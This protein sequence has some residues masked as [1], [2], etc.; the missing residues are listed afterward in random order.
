MKTTKDHSASDII[1]AG[2]MTLYGRQPYLS[3]VLFALRPYEAPGLGTVAVDDGW[4]LYYDPEI[5]KTW[6]EEMLQSKL[7]AVASGKVAHDGI[8][9]VIFHE[10]GHVMREHFSRRGEKDASWWNMAG[11][12]EINDDV[13][14]AGWVL[15]GGALMPSDLGKPNGLTAEEYYAAQVK[16]SKFPPGTTAG[17]PQLVKSRPGC[18]GKCGGGAGNPT[19]WEKQNTDGAGEGRQSKGSCQGV[20]GDSPI[21]SPID[22][23]EKEIILRRTALAIAE[24]VKNKGKGSVPGGL[25]AW[26]AKK[27]TPPKIDWR[28]RVAA[29]TRGALAS[30]AGACDFTWRKTGRRSLHSASRSGW[31]IAPAL[32]HPIPRMAVVLDT[33]GSMSSTSEDGRTAQNQA[34]SEVVGIALA[35]GAGVWVY[36]CDAALQAEAVVTSARD[37]EKVNKGGGGTSMIPGY[38]AAQTRKPDLVVIITDGYVGSDWPSVEECRGKR[39][40]AVIVGGGDKPP[41]HIPFVEAA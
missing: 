17:Y 31:P 15:P 40:L 16:Q 11:D 23:L 21:P 3:H 32:H 4:R 19:D 29:V 20:S 25:Q 7:D 8:P 2:R 35:S 6:H 22:N 12:R 28:R 39:V 33:S 30:A 37:L 41:R 1:A 24:H 13:V 26:A 36:A 27:L 34:L 9:A 18:G 14:A 10:L 38:R 5:V